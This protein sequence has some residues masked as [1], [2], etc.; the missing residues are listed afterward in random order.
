[1]RCCA[2]CLFCLRFAPCGRVCLA[3]SVFRCVCFV[4]NVL[5]DGVWFVFVRFVVL[6][7]C[8]RYVCASFACLLRGGVCGFVCSLCVCACFNVCVCFVCG[9]LCDIVWFAFDA[10]CCL[11]V[12][13][14]ENA[15]V[16]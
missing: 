15:C 16:L 7:A 1:M 9:L 4:W 6:P 3:T 12:C 2:V 5:C 13:L 8:V 11:F 14:L 10:C